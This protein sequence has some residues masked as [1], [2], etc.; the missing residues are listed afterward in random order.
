MGSGHLTLALVHTKKR[1]TSPNDKFRI[2]ASMVFYG[3]LALYMDVYRGLYVLLCLYIFVYGC[4][5]MLC[6]GLSLLSS[7]R[8]GVILVVIGSSML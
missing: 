1:R 5:V 3:F 4:M 6:S 7:L 2:I 8:Y